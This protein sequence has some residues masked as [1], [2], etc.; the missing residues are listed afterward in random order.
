[1]WL[2]NFY[3]IMSKAYPNSTFIGFDNH[4]PS[5]NYALSKAKE[6]GFGQNRVEFEVTSSTQF[7]G[8][9][10]GSTP[11]TFFDCFHDMGIFLFGCKICKKCSQM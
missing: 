8:D 1:M 7:P 9:N 6:E 2:W 4:A 3:I 10:Y 11:I 5:I